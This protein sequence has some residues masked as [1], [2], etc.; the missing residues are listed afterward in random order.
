VKSLA[1]AGIVVMLAA[2]S[3]V[4][5]LELLSAARQWVASAAL[6]A[7]A[8]MLA[9]YYQRLKW[10]LSHA[11]AQG[12]D[13]L[14]AYATETGTARALARKTC[15]QLEQCGLSAQIAELNQLA[16]CPIAKRG[17]LVVASTSGNGDAPRTGNSWLSEN[18]SLQPWQGARF[19]VLALGD[20]SYSQFCGFGIAVA[21]H[22]QQS[23]LL[24][25]FDPVLVHQADPQSVDFWFRQLKHQ[26]QR[27]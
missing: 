2:A 16:R 14:V 5:Q 8:A 13:Y 25:L 20:R 9:V 12:V 18:H 22:L 17:L 26:H 7:Y 6:L 24:P 3:W 19:A 1:A 10:Q 11:L 27:K 15:K 4:W 23:G 21:S